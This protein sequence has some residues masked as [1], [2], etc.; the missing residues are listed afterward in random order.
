MFGKIKKDLRDYTFIN[1]EKTSEK[2]SSLM[3]GYSKIKIE[4]F[5]RKSLNNM[6]TFWKTI[7]REEILSDI[8]LQE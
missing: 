3:F 4:S 2:I 1:K 7:K 6:V 8:L 5:F